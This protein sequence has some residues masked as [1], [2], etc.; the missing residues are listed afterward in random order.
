M[1][2]HKKHG[3]LIYSFFCCYILLF[4]SRCRIFTNSFKYI[5]DINS[6]LKMR[7]YNYKSV[8][9]VNVGTKC[10]IYNSY[11]DSFDKV[12]SKS[13]WINLEVSLVAVS[14]NNAK[15]YQR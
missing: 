14:H 3:F 7:R 11:M 8:S 13:F 9:S 15:L 12:K 10:F 5:K 1:D 4:T 6:S 2:I